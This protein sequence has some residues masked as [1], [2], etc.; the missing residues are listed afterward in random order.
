MARL[1]RFDRSRRRL[2][3]GGENADLAASAQVDAPSR[4]QHAA[5]R[6]AP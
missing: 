3:W 5:E 2:Y 4:G 6:A 1:Q